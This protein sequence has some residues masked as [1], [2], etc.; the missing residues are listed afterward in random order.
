[1]HAKIP[2]I[3]PAGSIKIISVMV[4]TQLM[5]ERTNPHILFFHNPIAR[6]TLTAQTYGKHEIHVFL[7]IRDNKRE[8]P[9]NAKGVA[10]RKENGNQPSP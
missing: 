8:I 5:M 10:A 1:M 9:A 7:Q 6:T 3:I 2:S 4:I